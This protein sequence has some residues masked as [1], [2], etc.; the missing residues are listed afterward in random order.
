M[1][2]AAMVTGL[3]MTAAG[4]ALILFSPDDKKLA[5]AANGFFVW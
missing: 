1:A 4:A 5:K 2:T 3:F